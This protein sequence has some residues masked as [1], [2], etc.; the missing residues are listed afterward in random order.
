MPTLTEI[1]FRFRNAVIDGDSGAVAPVLVGGRN[2]QKRLA[3]HRR[4]YET[5][6]V[7]ALLLKFPAT[8]WLIGTPLVIEAARQFIRRHPPQ[9]PCIAEYGAAFPDFLSKCAGAE[10]LPYLRDFAELEW[11]A[12]QVAIAIDAMPVDPEEFS[13]ADLKTLPDVRLTLQSGLRYLN[14]SWPVEN[15]LKLYLAETAPDQLELVPARVW[16]E[17]RGARGEFQLNRLD[18]ASFTF[19]KCV[20]EGCT[21]G[22]AAE[23]ALD[24]DADFDPGQALGAL[25]ANRFVTAVRQTAED[26]FHDRL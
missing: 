5:G 6:L 1:Q 11:L 9:A 24:A 23:R 3:I 21:L 16:I 18:V 8:R 17:V 4:N 14:A 25:I 7:D 12:G 26:K 22:E 10:R 19:R 2:P 13:K 15:L 20:S